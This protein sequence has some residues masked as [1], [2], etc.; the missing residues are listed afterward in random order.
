MSP[1]IAGYIGLCVGF[2]IGM[3]LAA[4]LGARSILSDADEGSD[5]RRINPPR[6]RS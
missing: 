4:I 5:G 3:C 1:L 2:C 6:W